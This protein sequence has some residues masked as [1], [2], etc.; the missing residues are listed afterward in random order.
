M[1]VVFDELASKE[2]NDA[3]EYYEFE[4]EGLGQKF[5]GEIKRAIKTLKRFPKIGVVEEGDIRRYILHKFPYKI[6]YSLEKEYIFIIA[7]AHMHRRPNYWVN[8]IKP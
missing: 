6:M 1:K 5:R 8:R 7:I 2:F 4:F 3:I